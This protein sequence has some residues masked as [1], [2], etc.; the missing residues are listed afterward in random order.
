MIDDTSGAIVGDL[1]ENGTPVTIEATL[2]VQELERICRYAAV[3]F[4]PVLTD[5]EQF[6]AELD[7]A[8]RTADS[9][10]PTSDQIQLP[11]YAGDTPLSW[12]RPKGPFLTILSILTILLPALFWFQKDEKMKELAKRRRELLD[13]DYSELLFKLTLLTAQV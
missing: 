6:S 10:D 3:V 1:T 12:S 5:K 13:L 8:L 11:A 9:S 2:K 7:T 4:P